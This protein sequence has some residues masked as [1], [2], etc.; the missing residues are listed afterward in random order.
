[1][2]FQ[3]TLYRI[4]QGLTKLSPDKLEKEAHLEDYIAQDMGILSDRWMLIGRQVHTDFG[5]FID[6]LA[7]DRSGTLIVIELK[8][9]LTPREV[10]AQAL[11]YAAWVE[12]LEPERIAIPN[13]YSTRSWQCWRGLNWP[14]GVS[15][16]ATEVANTRQKQ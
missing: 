10:V 13:S 12:G 9:D 14:R 8:K 4:D 5:K 2:P 1:M 7:V 15:F 16:T 11:D 3:H 6:L